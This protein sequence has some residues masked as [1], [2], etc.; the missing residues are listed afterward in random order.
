MAPCSKAWWRS[1][2]RETDV[3]ILLRAIGLSAASTGGREG[4]RQLLVT[5]LALSVAGTVLAA[6]SP[7]PQV[8]VKEEAGL[9]KVT[10]TIVVPQPAALAFSVLTDYERIPRFMPDLQA[11][12]VLERSDK[13]TVVEQEAVARFLMFS[14]RIHLVLEVQEEQATIRFRD[15]CGQSFA[16]YEGS[17]TIADAGGLTTITYALSAKPA[18]DVPGFMLGRLLKRDA[19][20]MIEGLTAEIAAR[21]R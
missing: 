11:S 9:Y 5:A 3:S 12:R 4:G 14:K 10:A 20:R 6:G 19:G 7:E 2:T 17:W 13:L 8:S 1:E 15:R 21:A 16:R 18:F